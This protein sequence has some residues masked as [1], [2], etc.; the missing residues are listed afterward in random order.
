MYR[1]SIPTHG[2]EFQAVA[3]ITQ[4]SVLN[5]ENTFECGY[6]DSLYIHYH[7]NDSIESKNSQRGDK[8]THSDISFDSSSL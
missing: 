3:V 6:L 7:N 4:I 8:E 5:G 1:H 2:D